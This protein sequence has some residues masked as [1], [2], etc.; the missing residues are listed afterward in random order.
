MSEHGAVDEDFFVPAHEVADECAQG[1]MF[2]EFSVKGRCVSDV[3]ELEGLGFGRAADTLMEEGVI[4]R[5]KDAVTRRAVG[6][7]YTGMGK[8]VKVALDG[9]VSRS[10]VHDT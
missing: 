9:M 5:V 6:F 3:Q 8:L 1:W 4:G 2:E 10:G 7:E